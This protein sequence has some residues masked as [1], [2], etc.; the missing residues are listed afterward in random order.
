ME[1]GRWKIDQ[2]WETRP[3][4]SNFEAVQH[5]HRSPRRTFTMTTHISRHRSL[6]KFCR[7]WRLT[8]FKQDISVFQ[9]PLLF[10]TFNTFFATS[11]RARTC[12][13]HYWLS[14]RPL[15]LVAA[16]HAPGHVLT[17]RHT[18]RHDIDVHVNLTTWLLPGSLRSV[19]DVWSSIRASFQ[20]LGEFTRGEY[21]HLSPRSM[22]MCF[23]FA[24]QSSSKIN[25]SGCMNLV[26]H[27]R[28]CLYR[29]HRED[30][31]PPACLQPP[32]WIQIHVYTHRPIVKV[33]FG[34][35]SQR[36]IVIQESEELLIASV[37]L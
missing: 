28:S 12:S 8:T 29:L 36:Q 17:S 26:G 30:T 18:S 31:V 11:W 19:T 7:Q 1:D 37:R 10:L 15:R 20:A 4:T 16:N 23:L 13:L 5:G 21:V 3:R 32:Y 35:V 34:D 25:C 33:E 9:V 6:Q 22:W 27:S 14:W 24:F 2:T